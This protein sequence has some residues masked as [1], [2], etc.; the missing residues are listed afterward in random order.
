MKKLLIFIFLVSQLSF[1]QTEKDD[2]ELYSMILTQQ[3]KLGNKS[4]KEKILLLEQFMEEFDGN[5][6]VLDHKSDS[7]TKLDMDM[8]YIMTYKDSTFIKRISNEKDLRNVIVQLTSDK[9]EHPKIHANLLNTQSIEIETIT[10]K[11]FS[12][13]FGNSKRIDKG[14]KRIEKKY[15]TDKV[16]EFSQVNYNGQFASTYYGIRCGSL[17]GAGNIVVFEKINGKWEILTEINLWM[18]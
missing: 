6:E 13:F 4:K 5:Y 2:Y 10:D 12:S 7:I 17:C 11:K 18:A 3:L 16:V 1:S 14:W 8:L 9:S 15:G